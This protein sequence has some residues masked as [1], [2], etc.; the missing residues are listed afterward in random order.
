M[1]TAPAP[2]RHRRSPSDGA[3]TR[4][5]GAPPGI[6]SRGSTIATKLGAVMTAMIMILLAVAGVLLWQLRDTTRTYDDILASEVRTAL[7]ARQMQVEFKK[8]VQEWKDI[9]LRGFTPADLTKYTKQF[10][11]ES[12][13]VDQ[14][15]TQLIDTTSDPDV[16]SEVA[17]FRDEHTALNRAYAD[18]LAPFVAAG[19]QD[20]R[21]PDRAVRGLDRPPTSRIDGIVAQQEAAVAARTAAQ[22]ADVA[23][24][25]TVLLMVGAVALVLVLAALRLVVTGIARPIRTLTRAAYQA[26]HTSLPEA[27]N[28][29]R[30]DPG[31]GAAVPLPPPVTVRAG[32]ELADLADALTS[33]QNSALVLAV[34][35][36][37]AERES[38]EALINLGR[39]N[40]SLLKRTLGY[41]SELEAEERD[42]AVLGRL[43]RLDHATTRIRR[44]AESMLVLA[45]ATQTRTWARPVP[46]VDLVRAALSEIEDYDRVDIYHVEDAAI[47]GSAAADLI[48]LVAELT[49]NA[50]HFSPPSSRVTII[51]QQLHDFYRL[52]VIDTGIG[53]TAAELDG[54]NSRIESG[55]EGRGDAALLGLNVVG[56]LA[57]RRNVTVTLEPSSGRGI[58]AS[59]LLP[60]TLLG[61]PGDPPATA[62]ELPQPTTDE[63]RRVLVPAP[64]SALVGSREPDPVTPADDG[65]A[66]RRGHHTVVDGDVIPRRVPGAQLPDLGP[67]TG[68]SFAA[69]DPDQAR[70]QLSAFADGVRNGR[71][72][73]LPREE[74]R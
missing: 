37:R 23:A 15:A 73:A 32:G 72:Q 50:T 74:Y 31:D 13:V 53:M 24:R 4:A 67:E 14:L 51:G 54:A 29:V 60:R 38:A 65:G 3:E 34:D 21:I 10:N 40:Q 11:D 64:R 28:A 26:A 30:R 63:H 5:A 56:R 22:S 20:P 43:F 46:V 42:P 36:H 9:L 1:T 71:A 58:T 19:A 12:A 25:Q 2:R 52:R 39:R 62:S 35:Q 18:A 48:H 61:P 70:R 45:G 44:N 16:R 59:V 17:T 47:S 27:V 69:P 41:I 49:E 6:R 68:A 33:M 7:Q 8:Q 55:A 66:A 57:A